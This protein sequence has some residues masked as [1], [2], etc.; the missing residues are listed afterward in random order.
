MSQPCR[1][2]DVPV[3][4]PLGPGNRPPC[5]NGCPSIDCYLPVES[6]PVRGS[7]V[8]PRAARIALSR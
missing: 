3:S 6:F 7:P 5:G 8:L 1:V 4:G 2:P